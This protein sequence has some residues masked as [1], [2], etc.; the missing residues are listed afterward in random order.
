MAT[1]LYSTTEKTI[2][3]DCKEMGYSSTQ[4]AAFLNKK[5]HAGQNVRSGSGVR[6]IK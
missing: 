2:I 6:K 5:E 1:K 4:I 3:H